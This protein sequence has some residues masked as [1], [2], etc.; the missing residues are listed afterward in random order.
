MKKEIETQPETERERI[1][2]MFAI[3]SIFACFIAMNTWA[4]IL[5]LEIALNASVCR[6]AINSVD[7]F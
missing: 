4:H 7:L 1:V 2:E 3:Y 5:S 6:Y